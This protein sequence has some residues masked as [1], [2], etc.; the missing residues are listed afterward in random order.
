MFYV[1]VDFKNFIEEL[2]RIVLKDTT[3]TTREVTQIYFRDIGVTS[4]N[5]TWSSVAP[6]ATEDRVWLSL[7]SGY[8]LRVRL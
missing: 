8:A 1:R 2:L 3:L 4:D 6:L 5:F 7:D